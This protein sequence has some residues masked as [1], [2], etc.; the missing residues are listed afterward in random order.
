MIFIST[1]VSYFHSLFILSSVLEMY[2]K[3]TTIESRAMNAVVPNAKRFYKKEKPRI[4]DWR[5]NT[6]I[7]CMGF[8]FGRRTAAF[9]AVDLD[10]SIVNCKEQHLQTQPVESITR[11]VTVGSMC[12]CSSGNMPLKFNHSATTIET[13]IVQ[14]PSKATG[15]VK[16]QFSMRKSSCKCIQGQGEITNDKY[17]KD[18]E[19]SSG[20]KR[21]EYCKNPFASEMTWDTMPDLGVQENLPIFLGVL[22]YKSPLSLNASLENWRSSQLTSDIPFV[23]T[24]LQLNKRTPADDAIIAKH[25]DY[26]NMTVTG[27]PSENLHPGRTIAKFCRAAEKMPHSHPN[28]EN[29][30]L[31]L[32]KDWH[33]KNDIQDLKAIFQSINSLMQRGV[34]YIRLTES[35]SYSNLTWQCD[36]E[37]IKW[38]CQTAH[39]HRYSNLPSVIRCD[40][41]LRYLEPFALVKDSIMYGCHHGFQSRRYIDWEEALQ[42]GRV[43]WTNSQWVLASSTMGDMFEHVEIDK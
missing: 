9:G 8:F 35:K 10:M 24:F 31:F 36:A 3:F 40:W 30:L 33:L 34:P 27:S 20:S 12:R 1:S 15:D 28:G 5:W 2:R 32:E 25:E 39:Q 13:R 11:D 37:G 4:F 29:L 17:L 14:E 26:F 22:S 43:A 19:K 16:K 7:F 6:F 38:T 42:D 21:D 18:M 41:F 23:N